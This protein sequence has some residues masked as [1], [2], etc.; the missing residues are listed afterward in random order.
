MTQTGSISLAQLIGILFFA[1]SGGPYG[2]EDVI[3]SAGGFLALL[4]LLLALIL[5]LGASCAHH[6][7]LACMIPEAGGHVAWIHRAFGPFYSFVDCA[8]TLAYCIFDAALYPGTH[9]E[10][11]PP[12][13]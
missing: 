13:T 7:E 4:G 3:G 12:Y 8:F 9:S 10:Y 11:H 2:F 5:W 6:R 1:V